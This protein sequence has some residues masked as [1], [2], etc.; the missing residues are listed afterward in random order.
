[1]QKINKLKEYLLKELQPLKDR[2]ESLAI[3]INDGS[4]VI[5]EGEENNN[6]TVKYTATII[7]QDS[8]LTVAQ[9]CYPLSIWYKKNQSNFE[10]DAIR[11]D[12]DVVNDT[13]SDI[14]FAIPL[15]ETIKP[16]ELEGITSL[17]TSQERIENT[18][19]ADTTEVTI[20][21]APGGNSL[22]SEDAA[23]E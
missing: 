3:Y 5:Y 12:A 9:L 15:S 18:H 1:M 7:V 22:G 23:S 20:V 11:F 13:L 2:P 10:K 17:K 6:F 4:L 21:R 19:Y 8:C 14:V 16:E